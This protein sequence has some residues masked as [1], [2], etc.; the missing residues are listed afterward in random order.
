MSLNKVQIAGIVLLF[1]GVFLS[2]TNKE[3][4]FK[5]I[6]AILIGLG[7]GLTVYKKRKKEYLITTTAIIQRLKNLPKNFLHLDKT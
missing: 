4:D 6:P 5:M 2:S 1:I 3:I 7:A